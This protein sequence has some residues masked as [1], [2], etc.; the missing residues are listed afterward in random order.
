M[1]NAATILIVDDE[2]LVRTLLRDRL[3]QCGYAT[4]E[5]EGPEDALDA[6]TDEVD[7]VLLEQHLSL[8]ETIHLLERFRDRDPDVPVIILTDESELERPVR[9]LSHGAFHYAS[10]SFD[11]DELRIYVERAIETS[12]MRRSIKAFQESRSGRYGLDR[13]IGESEPMIEVKGL[14]ARIAQG[15]DVTVLL[16]GESGTGKDLAAKIIHYNSTRAEGPF[17]NITCSALPETL[18]E[19][20]LFGHERGSFTGAH[21]QKKGLLERASGG[22]VFLDEI[23]EMSPTV[24]ASLLR[25]LEEKTFKRVGG[26]QD[27]RVN[28]RVI[29]ATNRRLEEEV[30]SGNFREDLYYRLSVLPVE[31]PPL[32]TRCGD[33]PALVRHYVDEFATEF[34]KKITGITDD[35][36]RLLS[37]HAWPGNIREL[38]NTVERAVIL[39]QGEKLT[40]ADFRMTQ[41]GSHASTNGANGKA[42]RLP[43][44]G[45]D[46]T[47]LECDLIRQAL[48]RTNGNQVEAAEL[49]GL[50][51]DQIRYRIKKHG[52]GQS[53]RP[54]LRV[55]FGDSR[56]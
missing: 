54:N 28:A 52:I 21:E 15:P 9:A 19:S 10:K 6:F 8:D 51:R 2:A 18:L 3:R 45:I 40:S 36:L 23:G 1:S 4:L 27:I 34:R 41:A 12:R 46:L 37:E 7:L 39:A 56:D 55:I 35:A 11:F 20:E 53:K 30:E 44:H 22:T 25:F 17:M 42:F 24:Q 5:A 49:V 50:T 26:S 29:A 32:R 31:L 47:E 13:I 43:A 33:I 48:E 38:K 14:L 16:T